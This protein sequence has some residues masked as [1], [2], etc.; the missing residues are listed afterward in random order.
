MTNTRQKRRTDEEMLAHFEAEKQRIL[1]RMQAKA[2]GRPVTEGSGL[3]SRLKRAKRT[4]ETALHRAQ[5]A[6]NGKAATAKSPAL[7]T[8]EEKIERAQKRLDDLIETQNRALEQIAELPK[9]IERLELLIEAEAAGDD[10]EFPK[11]LYRLPG[12]G[13]QT[14]GEAETVASIDQEND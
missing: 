1:D 12:E 3:S 5:V 11:G 7:P 13:E 8:I 2:E 14:E 10:V 6:V 4:R 9:D